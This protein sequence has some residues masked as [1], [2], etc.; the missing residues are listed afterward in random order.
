MATHLVHSTHANPDTAF[1]SLASAMT[2]LGFSFAWRRPQEYTVED[3]TIAH[4][5]PWYYI[6]DLTCFVSYC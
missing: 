6:N 5:M 2:F 1:S 3:A 4:V